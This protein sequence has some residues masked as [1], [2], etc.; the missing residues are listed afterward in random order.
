MPFSIVRNDIVRM[1]TD[2]VVNAANSGLRMGGG[3]CGA[4]FKAAGAEKLTAACE[5]IGFCPTG[6]AVLTDG[7]GLEAKYIIHAVGPVWNDNGDECRRLL[8][9]CYIS[10]L[11]LAKQHGIESIAF[12]LISSGIYGCPKKIASE[13]AISAFRDFLAGNEMDIVLVVFD[14]DSFRESSTY[15]S[16]KEYI[17]NVYAEKRL[18]SQRNRTA[19]DDESVCF[20]EAAYLP[21]CS[22]PFPM[23]HGE[24]GSDLPKPSK[25]SAGALCRRSSVKQDRHA[26][27]SM[28]ELQRDESFSEHLLRLIDEKGMT[29]V[30]AYK[31]AN[32]DRKLFSKIKSNR[33]YSPRKTTA[34]AFAIALELDLEE[35]NELL[36]KAGYILSGSLLFD[37]IIRYFIQNRN[38]DMFEINGVLFE[39]DQPLLGV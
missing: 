25:S 16:V 13:V 10:S 4:I 29:D 28:P 14:R 33:N 32:I 12:P 18:A 20:E 31:K 2:A 35:T 17:N 9:S 38:Y 23:A 3:V 36:C 21:E 5:K 24:A 15:C 26:A 37:L 34:V 7:F 11:E 27:L 22:E 39:F 6:S 8:Y 1:K 30:E 19:E